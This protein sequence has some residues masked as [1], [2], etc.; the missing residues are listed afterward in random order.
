MFN[1]RI[2]FIWLRIQELWT[3]RSHSWFFQN[4]WSEQPS[5]KLERLEFKCGLEGPSLPLKI[6]GVNYP[7]LSSNISGLKGLEFKG[8]VGRKVRFFFLH[9][10]AL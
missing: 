3:G 5:L 4:L 10:R 1:F 2:Y 8:G 7:V 6:Y 9:W